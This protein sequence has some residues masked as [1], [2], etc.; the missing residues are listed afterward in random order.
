MLRKSYIIGSLASLSIFLF[1]FNSSSNGKEDEQTIVQQV[2]N[3]LTQMHFSSKS[4]DNIFSKKVFKIYLES[5]DPYKRYFKKSD[6]DEFKKYEN[7]LDDYFKNE[8]LNF[9]NLTINRYLKRIEESE[10]IVNSI[11]E[12]NIEIELESDEYLIVDEKFRKYASNDSL[13]RDEWKKFLKHLIL[14]EIESLSNEKKFKYKKFTLEH[15]LNLD[16]YKKQQYSVKNFKSDLKDSAVFRV[17]EAM[18]DYFRIIK[19]KKKKDYFSIYINSF[20]ATFDPHT[21]YLSPKDLSQFNSSISGKII[22]IGARLQDK[23]G[24]PVFMELIVGGPAWK[25]KEIEIG[26]KIL[27]VGEANKKPENIVGMLLEDAIQ[28]IR[29]K[30]K[31]KVVLVIQK[32]DGSIRYVSL[33]REKIEM[34]ESFARSAIIEN[35]KREKFGVI[36]LP[37]FYMDVDNPETGRNCSEDFKKEILELQKEDIKGLIIDLRGNGGGSL[38]EVV[39]IVG[40]F[41]SKGAVVQVRRS[42]GYEQIYE[43]KDE[44]IFYNGSMIVLVDELSASASEIFAA[45][46][47]DYQRGIIL[48]SSKTFGKGTVQSVIPLDRFN[49]YSD[50]FGSLKLT[51][52]KFYRINGSST[53][54]KGVVPDIV[55][56]SLYKY[57]EISE[58]F[59]KNALPWDSVQPS[60]YKIYDK[61]IN[62][63]LV[64]FNSKKRTNNHPFLKKIEKK[65]KWIYL[66]NQ[67]KKIPLNYKKY[68]A[69]FNLKKKVAKKY[70][71]NL[72]YKTHLKVTNLKHEFL[73]IKND[74]ILKSKRE[75]WYKELEKDFYL[76]EAISIFRDLK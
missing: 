18:K 26:D 36:Y 38:P 59:Q 73:K 24:Y 68:K 64:K 71:L 76:A 9:Y 23:K 63:D 67:E 43:D 70:N 21:M 6:F 1:C 65:S 27:K 62:Y 4:I 58:S 30:E 56:A 32:K 52:Q 37:E 55:L 12:N 29:G 16:I 39:K 53:Q 47:Q 2:R 33:F 10:K 51:I 8:N 41:I 28:L 17:K 42:D 74:T 15:N 34:E 31:S 35:N 20:A 46:I 50:R 49:I 19:A 13:Y 40:Y 69:N 22:G 57:S 75:K 25:S 66:S 14:K 45:A 3:T 48:G 61:K 5:L 11:L 54:I 72:Y 7:K 60:N 44:S